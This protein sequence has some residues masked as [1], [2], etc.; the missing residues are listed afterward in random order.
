MGWGGDGLGRVA[1][2]LVLYANFTPGV[3]WPYWSGCMNNTAEVRLSSLTSS[4]SSE[5]FFSFF[6]SLSYMSSTM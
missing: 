2:T 1:H 6:F 5:L 3:P 4:L